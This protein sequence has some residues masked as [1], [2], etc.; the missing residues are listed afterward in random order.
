MIYVNN[1]TYRHTTF[2]LRRFVN[3]QE[4]L[5]GIFPVIERIT[6]AY[7]SEPA[8]TLDEF[9]QLDQPQYEAR[10]NS[11]FLYLEFKYPFFDRDQALA[12]T[13]TD[14]LACPLDYSIQDRYFVDLELLLFDVLG[15]KEAEIN[16]VL[17]DFNGNEVAALEVIE[18][19]LLVKYSE[20]Q[21]FQ[22]WPS[23]TGETMVVTIAEGS[24]RTVVQP[25]FRYSGT[26]ED[27]FNTKVRTM[28]ILAGENIYVG[29]ID[30]VYTKSTDPFFMAN[31]ITNL[32]QSV[33]VVP[34]TASLQ[35]VID[36]G[37]GFIDR[38]NIMFTFQSNV[39]MRPVLIY[40]ASEGS[41]TAIQYVQENNINIL[42]ANAFGISDITLDFDG[43]PIMFKVYWAKNQIIYP[44][45]IDYRFVF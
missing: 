36:S 15:N 21:A 4:K 27:I 37:Q 32:D 23:I 9:A 28:A 7:G 8:L 40:P 35:S 22:D 24:S 33:Q 45:S 31:I 2:I 25:R 44:Y 38:N 5:D 17:K 11:F 20:G 30:V 16:I 41:L 14:L 10:L 34:T 19:E 12:T 26:G 1:G 13:G 6:Q 39:N 29:N 43:A 18:V 3:G 42:D